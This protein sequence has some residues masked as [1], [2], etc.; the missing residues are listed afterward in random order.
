MDEYK[1]TEYFLNE[2]LRK[3]SYIETN[4]CIRIIENPLKVEKQ[5]NNRYRFWGRIPEFD[6]KVF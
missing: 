1:Y 5:E 4:W 2:V 6:N 3:R